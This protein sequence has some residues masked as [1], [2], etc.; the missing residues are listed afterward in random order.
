MREAIRQEAASYLTA[1]IND[2]WPV[3]KAGG[4]VGYADNKMIIQMANL[5]INYSQNISNSEMLVV[6]DAL[7]EVK[8]LYNA[9]ETRLHMSRYTLN[10]EIWLVIIIGTFITLGI[11]YLFGMNFYLHIIA[12]SVVSIMAASIIY[13]LISL[14][15][16]FQGDFGIEPNAFKAVLTLIQTD[17]YSQDKLGQKSS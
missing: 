9:R 1:V 5:L 15:R 7:E 14:D 8:D 6:R 3:M 10:M 17:A 11:N 12:V 16:P 13:L 2:E 4:R